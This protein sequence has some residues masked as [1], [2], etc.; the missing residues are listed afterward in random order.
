MNPPRA[1]GPAPAGDA[2]T[3]AA[4]AQ[5]NRLIAHQKGQ[6]A[7]L[8]GG[9]VELDR[10]NADLRVKCEKY[11]AEILYLRERMEALV[12]APADSLPKGPK[13][14][15]GELPR[16]FGEEDFDIEGRPELV[17]RLVEVAREAPADVPEL[18]FTEAISKLGAVPGNHTLRGYSTAE[19][20]VGVHVGGGVWEKMTPD[21]IAIAYL[22]RI[23]VA[24]APV[25]K[26]EESLRVGEMMPRALKSWAAGQGGNKVVDLAVDNRNRRFRESLESAPAHH[27]SMTR[28]AAGAGR[29]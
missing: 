11:W 10:D 16:K 19:D 13:D 3:A 23:S 14:P 5:A 6:I 22:E 1:A 9:I 24:L 25:A 12:S 8:S 21:A 20:L 17:Q 29:E 27:E 18:I 28:G 15:A 7:S 2:K 26:K 4:L